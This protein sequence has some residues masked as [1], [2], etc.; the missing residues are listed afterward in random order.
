MRPGEGGGWLM[1]EKD[2]KYN[3]ASGSK[4]YRWLESQM[5]QTLNKKI[6][7]RLFDRLA[8]EAIAKISVFGDF[9]QF[10]A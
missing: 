4:D 1:R 9:E 7:R 10:R 3:H 5:V 8:D 2:G 6:D